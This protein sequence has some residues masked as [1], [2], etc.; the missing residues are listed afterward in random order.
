MPN[1]TH[2]DTILSR[3]LTERVDNKRF[4]RKEVVAILKRG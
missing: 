1:V 3:L 2:I 4:I